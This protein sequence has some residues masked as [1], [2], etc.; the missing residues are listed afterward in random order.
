MCLNFFQIFIL[1]AVFDMGNVDIYDFLL[2]TV[3]HLLSFVFLC[4]LYE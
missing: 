1:K 4:M 2:S 3:S